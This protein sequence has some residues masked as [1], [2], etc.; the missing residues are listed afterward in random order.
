MKSLLLFVFVP[1]VLSYFN[2]PSFNPSQIFLKGDPK[3]PTIKYIQKACKEQYVLNGKQ[4]FTTFIDI[5]S[6]K[7]NKAKG[8]ERLNTVICFQGS[9][10]FGIA[11]TKDKN[12]PQNRD[13]FI[14]AVLGYYSRSNDIN[15]SDIY[16]EGWDS[17]C[18]SVI[19]PPYTSLSSPN[20]ISLELEDNYSD[21]GGRVTISVLGKYPITYN[22]F[23]V[24]S[25]LINSLK[26]L[27]LTTDDYQSK[28]GLFWYDCD[29]KKIPPGIYGKKPGI[30]IDVEQDQVAI[31]N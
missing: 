11:V 10:N 16:L 30:Y 14:A 13:S 9:P 28:G 1:G 8:S 22:C 23:G 18:V 12:N 6:L 25:G 2:Y 20:C 7:F 27:S 3:D 5:N 15:L 24:R 29:S 17:S 19:T 4:A 21:L 31:Q 26:Y